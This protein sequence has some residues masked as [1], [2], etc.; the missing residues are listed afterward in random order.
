MTKRHQSLPLATVASVLVRASV[1]IGRLDQRLRG[2]PLLPAFLLRARLQ[3]VSAQ[4]ATDGYH[5]DPWRLVAVL[6]GL[7]LRQPDAAEDRMFQ[8]DASWA[9]YDLYA[10]LA[11][12]GGRR[13]RS[14][15]AATR[16]I[17]AEDPGLGILLQAGEAYY[18]WIW[19]M[20]RSRAAMRAAL[21]NAWQNAGLFTAP[22]PLTASAAFRSDAP[23]DRAEWIADFLTE[24]GNEAIC[25]E[26]LLS[27]MEHAWTFARRAVQGQRST[28]RAGLVVDLLML[29]PMASATAIA[30]RTGLSI[31]A[32]LQILERLEREGIVVEIT[33]R[34]ARRLFA[35]RAFEGVRDCIR[36]PQRRSRGK[37]TDG[38]RESASPTSSSVPSRI[39]RDELPPLDYTDLEQALA[40]ADR[41]V[42]RFV[43]RI[44][45]GRADYVIV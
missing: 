23:T 29:H 24:L 13:Q 2:H 10:W 6:E 26:D 34:S 42:T 41:A 19:N 31:N 25:F 12:P 40:A 4:A 16:A 3:T 15:D 18:R 35:M 44:E 14:I 36:P 39:Q 38:P 22:V 20:N 45:L 5:I 32:T 28:S 30:Q 37:T 21:V 17:E 43:E 9:A 1:A 7:P 8:H 11:Y 27:R 33:N